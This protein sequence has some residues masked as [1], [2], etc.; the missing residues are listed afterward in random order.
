MSD[1]NRETSVKDFLYSIIPDGSSYYNCDDVVDII[2]REGPRDRTDVGWLLNHKD[3]NLA[4]K[5]NQAG[6]GAVVIRDLKNQCESIEN[7]PRNSSAWLANAKQKLKASQRASCTHMHT[8][9]HTQPRAP[10]TRACT[11]THTHTCTH[12]IGRAHQAMGADP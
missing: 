9:V 3:I 2:L 4:N 5:L 7:D 1:R 10:H 11:H 6:L 12:T 8:D